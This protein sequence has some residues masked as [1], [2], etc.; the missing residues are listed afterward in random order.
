MYILIN[1]LKWV[2]KDIPISKL[3]NQKTDLRYVRSPSFKARIRS[4]LLS[5]G[6][7]EPIKVRER[8]SEHYE[9][10]DGTTRKQDLIALGFKGLV[11]CLV[12][13]CS[14]DVALTL[15]CALSF[16]RKNLDP[17]GFARYV[18]IQHDTGLTL[19]KIG[20]PFNMKKAQVSKYLSL[21]KLSD[22]DKLRVAR[23]E[24]TIDQGYALTRRTRPSP[25]FEFKPKP[26]PCAACG[27]MDEDYPLVNLSLCSLCTERLKEAI[28]RE[29]KHTQKRLQ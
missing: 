3:V 9:I 8:D 24:L 26:M 5:L 6:I 15:Q 1:K 11:P 10:I 19:A 14:D 17:I 13:E 4:S 2:L 12:T 27:D 28:K 18:K 29:R 16:T 21:N 20:E 23:R 7:I 22:D 25:S